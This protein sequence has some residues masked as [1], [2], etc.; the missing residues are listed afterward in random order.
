MVVF[1][2][3]ITAG[4]RLRDQRFLRAG[5]RLRY[6]RLQT[7]RRPCYRLLRHRSVLGPEFRQDHRASG[8]SWPLMAEIGHY[9]EGIIPPTVHL[10][11]LA[12]FMTVG[13]AGTPWSPQFFSPATFESQRLTNDSPMVDRSHHIRSRSRFSRSLS[14]ALSFSLLGCLRSA[15]LG[16][17]RT[18]AVSWRVRRRDLLNGRGRGTVE[19]GM[20]FEFVVLAWTTQPFRSGSGG[21]SRVFHIPGPTPNLV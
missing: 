17:S 5:V 6:Q 19:S 11:L 10:V 2:S 13:D 4:E 15:S 21:V 1:P 8:P 12:V 14:W 20:V 9:L 7:L 16:C 18:S 3:P